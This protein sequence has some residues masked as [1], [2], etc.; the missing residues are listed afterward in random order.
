MKTRKLQ[1][2]TVVQELSEVKILKV[3]TRCPEKYMLVDLET[4]QRYIGYPTDGP[5]DWRLIKD[6]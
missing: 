6:A 1:D 3:K 2:G 4:G 5:S